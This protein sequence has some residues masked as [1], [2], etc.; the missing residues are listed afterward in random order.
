MLIG[1]AVMMKLITAYETTAAP[2]AIRYSGCRTTSGSGRASLAS[3]AC[4]WAGDGEYPASVMA[5]AMQSAATPIN[6][7]AYSCPGT[8]SLSASAICGP[9]AA[10]TSVP[11]ITI[12]TAWLTLPGGT[13]SADAKRCCC[14]NARLAPSTSVAAHSSQKLAC[15]TAHATASAATAASSALAMKALRRP[16]RSMISAAGIAVTASPTTVSDTGSV[17][18]CGSGASSLPMIPPRRKI[19]IMPAAESA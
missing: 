10:A 4:W 16:M 12:E 1:V 6:E 14:W 9:I 15:T 3:A 2:T 17:A 8:R 7:P 5:A 13:L 11:I 19:V 18:I